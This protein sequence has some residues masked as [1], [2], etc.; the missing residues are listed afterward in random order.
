MLEKETPVE[1]DGNF[2]PFCVF[3][4]SIPCRNMTLRGELPTDEDPSVSI[5]T[6]ANMIPRGIFITYQRET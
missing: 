1:L 5:C 4:P 6:T 2:T 3:I